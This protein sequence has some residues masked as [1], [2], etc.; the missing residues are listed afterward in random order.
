MPA[1]SLLPGQFV[2]SRFRRSA[3]ADCRKSLS[4]CRGAGRVTAV[5]AVPLDGAGD[6]R[7]AVR[8]G[9]VAYPRVWP[10]R[11][12][13]VRILPGFIETPHESVNDII[14]C[15]NVSENIILSINFVS[16]TVSLNFN[17]LFFSKFLSV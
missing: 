6:L 1:K 13:N 4:T 17:F 9:L 15:G 16:T 2:I 8:V 14:S 10:G 12:R 5:T 3:G 7:S 11:N